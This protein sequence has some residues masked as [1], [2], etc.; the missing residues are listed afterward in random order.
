MMTRAPH[1]DARAHRAC[2]AKTRSGEPCK[3]A[4]MPN[5]RCALHGGKSLAG[6]AHP[7]A[8]TG[9]YIKSMPARLD[10]RYRASLDDPELLALREEIA[11]VDARIHDLLARV[12]TG[13]SGALW[14]ALKK[15][16]DQLDTDPDVPALA[17]LQTVQAMIAQGV[18]DYDAWAEVDRWVERRRRLAE[19]ERKRLVEAQQII[20]TEQAMALL[21]A[22]VEVIHEHVH[23]RATLAAISQDVRRLMARD[24]S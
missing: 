11:L 6:W 3:R 17:K 21:G 16:L 15:E 8:R 24:S 18:A 20:T 1:D 2:G 7:N 10:E 19:S 22:V 5:G 14:R 23:D 12:E 13:E 9:R 4:P